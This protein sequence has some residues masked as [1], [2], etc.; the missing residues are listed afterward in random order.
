M[1]LTMPSANSYLAQ[2]GNMK[3]K[4]LIIVSCIGLIALTAICAIAIFSKQAHPPAQYLFPA[5]KTGTRTP[6]YISETGDVVDIP[7][8]EDTCRINSPIDETERG[9]LYPAKKDGLWGYV[10]PSGKWAIEPKFLYALPFHKNSGQ[11]VVSASTYA[12]IDP[13]GEIQFQWEAPALVG[14]VDNNRA[15]KYIPTNEEKISLDIIDGTGNIVARDILIDE[16]SV[17][18]YYREEFQFERLAFTEGRLLVQRDGKYG[19]LNEN[20]EWIVE[21]QY[22]DA[23]QYSEGLAAVCQNGKYGYIDLDGNV[24]I[25]LQYDG[26]MPFG[27]GL[28]AIKENNR[29]KFITPDNKKPFFVTYNKL[30]TDYPPCLVFK[31]GVCNVLLDWWYYIDKE[32]NRLWD[33]NFTEALP[34]N[35]GLAYVAEDYKKGY[36]N[37][38]GEWVYSWDVVKG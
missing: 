31:E 1:G 11:V 4:N 35:H 37:K 9:Y 23:E 7:G 30:P 12:Y 36:I 32:E 2:G 33:I 34:F 6:V 21:P 15:I 14:P 22:E 24:A 25:P 18:F 26:A 28:A 20:G 38:S 19:F 13:S 8:L 10:F 3:R 27:E 17:Q 29:W 16:L 5:G